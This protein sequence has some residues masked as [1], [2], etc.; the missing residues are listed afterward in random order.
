[1]KKKPNSVYQWRGRLLSFLL[2]MC[3][4]LPSFAGVQQGKVN[5]Q[6]S[7]VS[8]QE[9]IE[10]IGNQTGIGFLYRGEEL[11]SY[12]IDEVNFTE[13]EW[14]E[15]LTEILEPIGKT[16]KVEKDLILIVDKPKESPKSEVSQEKKSVKGKVVDDQGIPLPGVNEIVS[17]Y[18]LN[19]QTNR[20]SDFIIKGTTTNID[21]EYSLEFEEEKVFLMFSFIGMTAKEVAYEGQ[22]VINVTLTADQQSLNEVVVTGYQTI[23]KERATGSF[24]KIDVEE[25][26]RQV[27][28]N[29][30]DKFEGVTPGLLTN[31]TNSDGGSKTSIILRG[32]SSFRAGNEA[33]IVVDGFPVEGGLESINPNDIASVNILQDAAATSIWG[34]RA[35]NGVVVI[36]TKKGKKGKLTV[37]FSAFATVQI[38]PDLD[39]LQIADSRTIVNYLDHVAKKGLDVNAGTY[40][41]SNEVNFALNPVLSAYVRTDFNDPDQVNAYNQLLDKYRQTDVFPQFEDL[42][43]RTGIE[44]QYN[45]SMRSGGEKNSL[46]FS[47]SH[48]DNKSV[49]KGDKTQRQILNL[50][51]DYRI[52]E[53]LTFTL[54]SNIS[55]TRST[56]NSNGFGALT[57]LPRFIMFEDENGNSI[58]QYQT[59][60]AESNEHTK[61]LGFLDWSSNPVDDLRARDITSRRVNMRWQAGLRWDL[62]K[63]FGVEVKGQYEWEQF[64]RKDNSDESTFKARD[65]IN[66]WTGVTDDKRL[67]YNV[68]F[69]G[70]FDQRET[71]VNAYYL[72]GFVDYNRT[73]NDLHDITAQVGT[74]YTE[75]KFDLTQVRYL[76]YNEQN[77]HYNNNID[78]EDLGRGIADGRRFVN[79]ILNNPARI[80]AS[81]RRMVSTFANLA[82]T[83]DRRYTL[84][85]SIKSD[86]SNR[87][88]NNK[89]DPNILWSVGGA[90]NISN[91]DF[92]RNV[93]FIN[94]LKLR[95]SYGVSGNIHE[96]ASSLP[97]LSPAT[98]KLSGA[99]S[100]VLNSFGNSNLTFEDT[101]ESNIG[102]DFAMFKN[103]FSG[104]IEYYNER[105]KNLLANFSLP[106]AL[107]F[108]SVLL[109]NGEILNKGVSVNLNV[110]I[111]KSSG[112]NW[113]AN[114]NLTYND[115]E[116]IKYELP[117]TNPT[118]LI[119]SIGGLYSSSHYLEGERVGALLSYRYA[120]LD[121]KGKPQVYDAKGNIIPYEGGTLKSMDDLVVT[122][123]TIAPVYGGFSNTFSYKNFSLNTLISFKAGHKFRRPSAEFSGSSYKIHKD[124]ADAWRAGENEDTMVPGL[125]NNLSEAY[126]YNNFFYKFSNHLVEDA[127]FI[128]LRQVTLTY[129]MP[130]STLKALGIQNISLSLQARNLGLLWTANDYD[131]DP[132]ALPFETPRG[133]SFENVTFVSRA[134]IRPQ[135]SYSLGV[136]VQF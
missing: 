102:V 108:K 132:E 65:I 13:K 59:V 111:L 70:V 90:W 40:N 32:A 72:R 51:D 46:Y 104:A 55:L 88:G 10:E 19:E 119:S 89:L 92:M 20:S 71:E 41:K 122:G 124:M 79:G 29:V 136:K 99:S 94:R 53:N 24:T 76:G 6:M 63:G 31:V 66:R 64:R 39:D 74:E 100:F 11:K 33:L 38:K 131:L 106:S 4:N 21:G 14:E 133:D 37:D 26:D 121:D 68:P 28:T 117:S 7:S 5:L 45:L 128:R 93:D 56:H 82:Y 8:V 30:V 118:F 107:G 80:S 17:S 126:N 1:M 112:F 36:T 95:G 105:S 54:A 91:E 69:G 43:M 57:N 81:D 73:F 83:Y 52:T 130:K 12:M 86:Q 110:A 85:G 134:P 67:I 113:D 35:S 97:V 115:S 44:Q 62:P 101:Y 22:K 49:L 96:N 98:N 50:K 18:P 34:V 127:S 15:V 103:R 135:P 58:P 77:A 61:S 9:V 129:D 3:M 47:L 27:T 84:T 109:N 60:D 2:I 42:L 123:T 48:N 125:P 75:R 16:F 114:F 78:W 116:V 25:M 120:G 23:S 87:V